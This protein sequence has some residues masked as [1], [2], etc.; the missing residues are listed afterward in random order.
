[1]S[2]PLHGDGFLTLLT[3]IS[4]DSAK[5]ICSCRGTIFSSIS[6]KP[7]LREI[8][9]ITLRR[10]RLMECKHL[11]HAASISRAHGALQ[12]ALS[13][14]TRLSHLVGDCLQAGLDVG[15]A[16]LFES[17]QVLWSHGERNA[18]VNMLKELNE[19]YTAERLRSQAL[20]V[21]KAGLL[22]RLVRDLHYAD[23][24]STL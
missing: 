14:A 21:G 23:L 3:H 17:A 13:S 24:Y 11:L 19:N 2:K 20:H 5:D 4:F 9:K 12:D 8:L 1:M 10:A 7:R 6:K 22:A 18:S 15:A 16:S